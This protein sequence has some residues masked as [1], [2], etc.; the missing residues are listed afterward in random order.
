MRYKKI[1][2]V[3]PGGNTTVGF[4]SFY[5]YIITQEEANHIFCIK[6][7]PGVGKSS[8]MKKI[9]QRLSD[10]G[11][12]VEFHHCS[13]DPDSLD[14]VVIKEFKIAFID[15]TAPHIVD[16]KNPGAVD[17]IINL[18]DNWN[19]KGLKKHRDNIINTN[20]KIEMFFKRAYYYLK[21][22]R[23]IYNSIE[24]LEK[25]A[26]DKVKYNKIANDI[27]N[28]VFGNSRI[29][30]KEGKERHLFAYA[31]TPVGLL[32][33][34][35]SI[36]SGQNKHYVLNESFGASSED[37]MNLI[38]EEAIR[39]G[40]DV[41]CFHSPLKIEKIVDLIIPKLDISISASNKYYEYKNDYEKLFDLTDLLNN[42]K[43][44]QYSEFIKQDVE[45]FDRLL[46][47]AIDNIKQTKKDHDL[48]E[49]N[50]ISNMNFE[51]NELLVEKIVERVMSYKIY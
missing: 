48:L 9:G 40:Y 2:H 25:L 16:P 35:E 49:I 42:K 23:N 21:S 5:K 36:L 20:K 24:D 22:A 12:S 1:R 8:L 11:Y 30:S 17:E 46:N 18:G 6:G 10:L 37:I 7:G 31:I 33:Y 34:R 15:G 32:D 3:F 41:E 27:Q 44:E 38:F 26:L 47:K 28:Q 51:K 39:K 29:L 19:E 13:S 4:Y 50:Y 45:V 43:Y 14:G